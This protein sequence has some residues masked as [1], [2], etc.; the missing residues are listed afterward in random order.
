MEA[1]FILV[2]VGSLRHGEKHDEHA[3]EMKRAEQ[4]QE[5]LHTSETRPGTIWICLIDEILTAASRT[6][7]WRIAKP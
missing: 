2:P 3:R 5:E 1:T 6:A 7:V 4:D